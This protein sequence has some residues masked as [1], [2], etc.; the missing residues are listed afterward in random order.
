MQPPHV[1]TPNSTKAYF[2]NT[3]TLHI[4]MHQIKNTSTK[5]LEPPGIVEPKYSKLLTVTPPGG[6][7]P[8][9]QHIQSRLLV[10]R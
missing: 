4:S 3:R 9:V 6:Y 2:S 5:A 1:H 8:H 7:G 10:D